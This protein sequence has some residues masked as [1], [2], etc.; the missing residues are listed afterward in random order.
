LLTK[1]VFHSDIV[2]FKAFM[3]GLI[4]FDWQPIPED[5]MLLLHLSLVIVLMLIFP[6]S[7]LLHG[8]GI[9]F[10]P[11]RNQVDNPREK[12]HVAPWAATMADNRQPVTDQAT[13]D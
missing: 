10:S 2:A 6:I 11:T 3:L 13:G 5:P 7:K 1:Y 9:L 8:P 4:R 12:R